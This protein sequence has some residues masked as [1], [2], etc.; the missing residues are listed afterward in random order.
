MSQLQLKCEFFKFNSST[1]TQADV[2]FDFAKELAITDISGNPLDLTPDTYQMIIKATLGGTSLLTLDE[3]GTN[4]L[5]GLY[6]PSPTS[7][8][9]NI[10]ITDTD[11]TAAGAGDYFYEMTKTDGDGK[12]FVFLQGNFQF[13]DRGF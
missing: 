6:I 11:T 13:N 10:Q 8:I 1:C 4:L 3:V 5:T 12:I 7:G 9:I 2:G